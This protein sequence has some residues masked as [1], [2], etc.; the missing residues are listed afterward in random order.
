LARGVEKTA[1]GDPVVFLDLIGRVAG[2]IASVE[3]APEQPA[4][5]DGFDPS[6][7][8]SIIIP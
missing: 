4:S 5:A 8:P 2:R 6:P 3:D 1:P 7:Q